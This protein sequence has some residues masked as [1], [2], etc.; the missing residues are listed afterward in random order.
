MFREVLSV[1]FEWYLQTHVRSFS[2][3]FGSSTDNY[4]HLRTPTYYPNAKRETSFAS[5]ISRMRRWKLTAGQV[6]EQ[7]LVSVSRTVT[8][9]KP[10]LLKKHRFSTLFPINIRSEGAMSDETA[11]PVVY[12]AREQTAHFYGIEKKQ[13]SRRMPS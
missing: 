5:I 11:L 2:N 3:H 8:N 7:I 12:Q 9:N 6:V 1:R 10:C 13:L 4:K